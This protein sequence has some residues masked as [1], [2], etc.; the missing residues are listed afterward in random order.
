MAIA[1][2]DPYEGMTE[3][4]IARAEEQNEYRLAQNEHN[5]RSSVPFAKNGKIA[6]F[7]KFV[8]YGYDC[9]QIYVDR[10]TGEQVL[11]YDLGDPANTNP[12]YGA[13]PDGDILARTGFDIKEMIRP[14]QQ[15]VSD[16][17]IKSRYTLNPPYDD[18]DYGDDY[19]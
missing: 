3:D 6:R 2:K 12:Y 7:L 19:E 11:R 4:Q 1:E 17:E 15:K 18:Y 5:E 9:D 8:D 10:K 13:E 14:D 16:E